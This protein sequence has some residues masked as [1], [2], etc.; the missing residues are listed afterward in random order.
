MGM[1][2]LDDSGDKGIFLWVKDPKASLHS[3]F[4]PL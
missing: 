1:R 2:F 4:Q 3:Q